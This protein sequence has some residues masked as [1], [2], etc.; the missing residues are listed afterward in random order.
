MNKPA[1]LKDK[2]IIASSHVKLGQKNRKG[3]AYTDI[4]DIFYFSHQNIL[5]Q[6]FYAFFYIKICMV[7][8]P[9]DFHFSIFF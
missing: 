9:Q 2:R 5:N 1:E 3:Q 8:I 6:Y 7:G 4:N